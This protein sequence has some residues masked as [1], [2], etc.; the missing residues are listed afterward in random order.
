MRTQALWL[1]LA[2]MLA[3]CACG[4]DDGADRD[5]GTA[6]D[7]ATPVDAGGSDSGAPPDGGTIEPPRDSGSTSGGA[8][9]VIRMVSW[10][11]GAPCGSHDRTVT[12]TITADDP[13]S[14]PTALLFSG[15]V[16]GCTGALDAATS[17]VTCRGTSATIAFIHVEDEAGHADD[18]AV[19][20]QYCEDGSQSF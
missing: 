14:A 18:E 10:V 8:A 3:L 9:P 20:I 19:N 6:I 5:S 15:N 2:C 1:P 7:A 13:D 12:I 17:T 11:H 4:D 16:G